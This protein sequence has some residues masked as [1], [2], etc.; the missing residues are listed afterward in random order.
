MTATT[1][2]KI[3]RAIAIALDWI[4]VLIVVWCSALVIDYLCQSF[5]SGFMISLE[6]MVAHAAENKEVH[7]ILLPFYIVTVIWNM[8]RFRKGFWSKVDI[9]M[10]SLKD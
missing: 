3:I 8:L 1:F 7:L 4:T 6:M 2:Q 9:V 10:Q 5:R